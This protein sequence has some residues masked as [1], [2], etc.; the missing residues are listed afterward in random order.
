MTTI[1]VR[2]IRDDLSFGARVGGVTLDNVSDPEVRARL[3]EL[4]VEQL[5]N[6][7]SLSDAPA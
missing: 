3:N 2:P 1:T 7:P 4:I 6:A 5:E